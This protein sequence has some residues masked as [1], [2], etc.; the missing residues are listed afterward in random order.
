MEEY[1]LSIICSHHHLCEKVRHFNEKD[2]NENMLSII[3]E[4]KSE[5]DN[6]NL[7]QL[8]DPYVYL[9]SYVD[10]KDD[11][12]DYTKNDLDLKKVYYTW[13]TVGFRNNL[14]ITKVGHEDAVNNLRRLSR[15]RGWF[16]YVP[17]KR[18]HI[19]KKYDAL[20]QSLVR[21]DQVKEPIKHGCGIFVGVLDGNMK[22]IQHT[23]MYIYLDNAYT[24]DLYH[25]YYSVSFG[26]LQTLC[27]YEVDDSR[28]KKQYNVSADEI[29]YEW[30]PEGEY[31]L[32]CPPSVTMGMFYGVDTA[33]WL[34]KI[35]TEIRE[36]CD[37]KVVVRFKPTE[38]TFNKDNEK[39]IGK[40]QDKL[41]R[42]DNVQFEN[43]ATSEEA[44]KRS[45]CVIGFN[46]RI[47]VE[48]FKMGKPVSCDPSCICSSVSHDIPT[49][50]SKPIKPTRE[51][52]IDFLK[53]MTYS[54]WTLDELSKGEHLKYIRS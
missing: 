40:I 38:F 25:K 52:Y 22:R 37:S 18:H 41:K 14:P 49:V 17:V 44:I 5:I 51:E 29:V 20:T 12:W 24:P 54:H 34:E 9:N 53:K 2:H 7:K 6:E 8:F 26:D 3:Q 15:Y 13:I 16:W 48:A 31:I 28:L 21:V 45:R 27:P 35:I 50:I 10:R 1:Y 36:S 32:L 39:R 47:L 30:C 33:E 4:C 11:F 43:S 19:K 23:S 46:S 42:F